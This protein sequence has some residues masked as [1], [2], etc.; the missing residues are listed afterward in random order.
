MAPR[1]RFPHVVL[2][3]S[4]GRCT[5]AS[6]TCLPPGH[7]YSLPGPSPGA[8]KRDAA[9]RC[10]WAETHLEQTA[11][12][13]S[14]RCR[15]GASGVRAGAWGRPRACEA[16]TLRR[17]TDTAAPQCTSCSDC[18]PFALHPPVISGSSALSQ[19]QRRSPRETALCPGAVTLQKG[20]TLPC[21]SASQHR[22]SPEVLACPGQPRYTVILLWPAALCMA[23]STWP[24]TQ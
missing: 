4:S 22:D 20:Q 10:S 18:V 7:T 15:P 24:D 9:L 19:A 1:S 5:H 21:L 2:L 16:D 17:V 23:P 3:S 14:G 11:A 6:P 8:G 13:S 12:L